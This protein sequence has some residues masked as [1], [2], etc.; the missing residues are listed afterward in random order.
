MK[1]FE[2]VFYRAEEDS[3]EFK[4]AQDFIQNWNADENVFIIKDY[5]KGV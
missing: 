5:K 3:A 4:K 1:E 2:D